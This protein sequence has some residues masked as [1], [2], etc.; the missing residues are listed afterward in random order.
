[1]LH[2]HEGTESQH[3]EHRLDPTTRL[4]SVHLVTN[5]VK[6]TRLTPVSFQRSKA[7]EGIFVCFRLDIIL[8]KI[9]DMNEPRSGFEVR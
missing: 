6:G 3:P 7:L 1:M 4:V 9:S 5:L 8:K 2:Y